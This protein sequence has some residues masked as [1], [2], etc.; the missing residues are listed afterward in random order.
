MERTG[1]GAENKHLI[2]TLLLPMQIFDESC[3]NMKVFSG[4]KM[5]KN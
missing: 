3:K 5:K 2:K 4:T 1:V